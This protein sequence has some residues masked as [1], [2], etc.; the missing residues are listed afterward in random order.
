MSEI[1]SREENGT[2]IF[3]KDKLNDLE[4][5]FFNPE[6]FSKIGFP[7]AEIKIVNKTTGED[8]SSASS[9]NQ[10]GPVVTSDVSDQ[11]PADAEIL[12]QEQTGDEVTQAPEV[13]D[14]ETQPQEQPGEVVAPEVIDAETQPQE[15]TG[16]VVAPE[17]TDAQTLPQEQT[18][19]ATTQGESAGEEV[20]PSEVS[21][22]EPEPTT[23]SGTQ[24][25]EDRVDEMKGGY[26]K[27]VER[28]TLPFRYFVYFVQREPSKS[29]GIEPVETKSVTDESKVNERDSLF[30]TFYDGIKNTFS[31]VNMTSSQTTP[32]VDASNPSIEPP[33]EGVESPVENV[34]PPAEDA[35]KKT[36]SNSE[37]VTLMWV[38]KIPITTT[39]QI[40]EYKKEELKLNQIL[41]EYK[42]EQSNNIIVK[43]EVFD[44]GNRTIKIA[45]TVEEGQ[46]TLEVN[47]TK[48]PGTKMAKYKKGK[49][50]NK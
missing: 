4:I 21:Y 15:Q 33:A 40:N 9:A 25:P 19:D 48:L 42:M 20:Q 3:E 29:S 46:P 1:R 24:N 6:Y 26:Y 34:E 43:G 14:A 17:V 2:M 45:Q 16:E 27:Y 37:D 36:D 10:V 49:K 31:G 23:Q 32:P 28:L 41:R 35:V 44:V 5:K 11:Q 47:N 7:D 30:H 50:E 12:P 39:G 8:A 13:T 38:V 18:G 22:P